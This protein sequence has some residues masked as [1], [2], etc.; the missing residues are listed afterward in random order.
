MIVWFVAIGVAGAARGGRASGHRSRAVAHLRRRVHRRPSGRG[1]RRDGRRHAR[2]HR[3]RGAL[4]RHGPLRAPADP[5]RLVR[6]R[7]PGAHAELPRSVRARPAPAGR[8]REPVLPPP[9][10]LGAHPDGAAGDGRHRDRLAGRHLRR[11]LGLAP[12]RADGLP[13]AS[14]RSP[15]VAA[16]DRPDLRA[17]RQLGPLR[18]SSSRSSS[19]SGPRS[20][21]AAPTAS[22]SAAPSSSRP[23][24]SWRSRAGAGAGRGG[25]CWPA[26]RSS[27]RSRPRSWPRT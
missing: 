22:R 7:V 2:D 19:A 5:P 11:V 9:P 13:A 14:D 18:R 3:R 24:S 8:D 4:R 21:S 6:A 23:C 15:H 26:L 1:L 16:R 27:C 25:C 10:A 17:G 20:G 12:G